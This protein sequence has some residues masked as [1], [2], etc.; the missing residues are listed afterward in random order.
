VTLSAVPWR[1]RQLMTK[2][3]PA[4]GESAFLR[5][6]KIHL[7]QAIKV[8]L[9]WILKKK[10]VALVAAALDPK[11]GHLDYIQAELRGQVWE[12]VLTWFTDFQ[13]MSSSFRPDVTAPLGLSIPQPSLTRDAFSTIVDG[14]R[15]HHESKPLVKQPYCPFEHWKNYGGLYSLL[16]PF[17]KVILAIPAMTAPSERCFSHA[18]NLSRKL[19]S[20]IS[21]ELLEASTVLQSFFGQ[22]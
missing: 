3:Q 7:H 4:A 16:L 19:R 2:T 17:V 14:L 13:N 21:E 5:N 22:P 11:Y 10:N 1:V 20:R 18:G 8:R 6:L 12:L 9:G 15:Q